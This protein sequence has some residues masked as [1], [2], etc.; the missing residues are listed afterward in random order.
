MKRQYVI[1]DLLASITADALFGGRGSRRP[2]EPGPEQP[3]PSTLK[4]LASWVRASG[5]PNAE[6]RRPAAR[7]AKPPLKDER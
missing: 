6:A 1:P 7:T 2:D 3:A 5:A 4:R